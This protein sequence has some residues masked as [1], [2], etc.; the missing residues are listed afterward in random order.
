[1][2]EENRQ[3]AE[4]NQ[5]LLKENRA[6]ME[7]SLERRDQHYSQQTEYQEK[8]SELRREKQKL[9]EKIMDQYRVL[10]PSMQ[11]PS[12]KAK[13]SNWIADRMKKLI[14][15]RGGGRDGR[16]LFT[17]A[18]SV[19]NLA[20]STEFTSDPH[21]PH[22]D[23]RSA[24]VSPSPLRKAP[25][26]TEQDI[27]APGTP[28]LR[29]GSGARRKLGSR[30]G[31]GLGLTRGGSGVSQSFS[32]GDHKTPPLLRVRSDHSSSSVLWEGQGGETNTDAPLNSQESVEADEGRGEV[33]K[34]D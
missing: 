3:L 7:Q 14:K 23:P 34:V 26:Q 30:H 27:S 29:S 12:S 8:L 4:Q 20:D 22:P 5:G 2:E 21:T 13:K 32:P 11:P 10:E 6:L 28:S 17:A 9:V 25:S 15:P 31:W 18:G 19:E 33:E 1:M 24:P 16:A